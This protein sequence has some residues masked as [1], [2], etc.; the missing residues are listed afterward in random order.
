MKTKI[1]A[2]CSEKGGVGKT[3]TT[4]NIARGLTKLGKKVL[5][6]D[7]DQQGNASQ[8][9]GYI[10]DGKYTSSEL[11]YNTIANFDFEVTKDSFIQNDDNV[12]YIPASQLLTGITSFMASDSDSNYV[13]KRA[14]ANHDIFNTYDYILLDCRTVLDLLVSNA[15][16]ASDYAIIPVESGVYSF[17]GL[18]NML[19]KVSSINN[20]TNKNL[21]VLGILLNKQQRTTVSISIADSVREEYD[22]ITFKTSIPFCPAQAENAIVNQTNCVDDKNSSIGKAF[23]QVAEEIINKVR[24]NL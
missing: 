14:L 2:V 9:F 1:I 3:T 4:V 16:N 6:I 24:E 23:L 21:K 13:I 10:K 5:V 20:S 17:E 7:L 11:L 15:L 12:S 8:A 18:G 19:D 22:D